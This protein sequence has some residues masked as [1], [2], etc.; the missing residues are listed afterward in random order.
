MENHW[1]YWYAHC[2]RCGGEGELVIV[3]LASTGRMAFRCDECFWCCDRPEH[4]RAYA[5]GYEG[6]KLKFELP[7][8]E[9]IEAAGWGGYCLHAMSAS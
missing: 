8:R 6:H 2:P 5:D 4:V 7:S 1:K 3:R 9:E